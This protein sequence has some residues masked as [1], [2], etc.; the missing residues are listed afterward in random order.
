MNQTGNFE[1]LKFR[2]DENRQLL[3]HRGKATKIPPLPFEVLRYFVRNPNRVITKLE[4]NDRVWS[5]NDRGHGTIKTC[6]G[7]LRN[8][9]KD[10]SR[11][12][13]RNV[14][15]VGYEFTPKVH[16]LEQEVEVHINEGFL[17]SDSENSFNSNF[18]I[19]YESKYEKFVGREEELIKA[20]KLLNNSKPSIL[21][22][23]GIM[24]I[25]K[26]QFAI[27]FSHRFEKDYPGGCYW[28][29][30]EI[31]DNDF[32][33]FFG[34]LHELRGPLGLPGNS[35]REKKESI[36]EV[37]LQ[38]QKKKERALLIFDNAN[39]WE[40]L[41]GI[42]VALKNHH[43][44]LTTTNPRL[45]LDNASL[46]PLGNLD[47][48]SS[49]KLL[50]SSC[51]GKIK[52][53][54]KRGSREGRAAE[55]IV[56]L[57]GGHAFS[58]DKVASYFK[59]PLA[60]DSFLSYEKR[61]VEEGLTRT[62][63]ETDVQGLNTNHELRIVAAL[64]P[65]WERLNN[66]SDA[67]TLLCAAACFSPNPIR[68]DLLGKASGLIS[69][70][71]DDGTVPYIFQEL[72]KN[73]KLEEAG[74]NLEIPSKEGVFP[75]KYIVALKV[76]VAFGLLEVA[77]DK[78]ISCH[79]LIGDFVLNKLSEEEK[80]RCG[81][82]VG[83][84]LICLF[85][86]FKGSLEALFWEVIPEYENIR[87]NFDFWRDYFTDKSR[88]D[89]IHLTYI[90]QLSQLPLFYLYNG[91]I[92]K[93]A[94]SNFKIP[95]DL[96]RS[97]N[98]AI[99]D[100]LETRSENFEKQG[101]WEN[102]ITNLILAKKIKESR[103][104]SGS[105]WVYQL[106][107][108][109]G[110]NYGKCGRFVEAS[111]HYDKA[112]EFY[113]DHIENFNPDFSAFG[114][115]RFLDTLSDY[116]KLLCNMNDLY[117]KEDCLFKELEIARGLLGS[118]HHIVGQIL[119][120]I[121]YYYEETG[122]GKKFE[123]Y[124]KKAIRIRQRFTHR[125]YYRRDMLYDLH[126]YYFN[127]GNLVKSSI[128]YLKYKYSPVRGGNLKDYRQEIVQIKNLMETRKYTLPRV[129]ERKIFPQNANAIVS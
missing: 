2:F 35:D 66:Y 78:K 70:L 57:L 73:G 87:C 34:S 86:N 100:I 72:K 68:Q 85:E 109:L 114:S 17:D 77:S 47:E 96:L 94:H 9:L 44:L 13:I 126:E 24:G 4:L 52:P 76:C 7:V 127:Q 64:S 29:E 31:R 50:L 54:P 118:R 115:S 43:R 92:S 14:H 65:T 93:V 103:L 41:K 28:I 56:K 113:K 22:V 20:R 48:S 75:E 59:D 25:G 116:A 117:S 123:T 5:G 121:G 98:L 104:G 30:A 18:F 21:I 42:V 16:P 129:R 101:E 15:G 60:E 95:V 90:G 124:R 19:R 61:L 111:E 26:T 89:N 1:F 106:V 128:Y 122:E 74:I 102:A 119:R 46:L 6:I 71:N 108:K 11:S 97:N 53:I 88:F 82:R 80:H 125:E 3:W 8:F 49:L 105:K 58:L 79:R 91:F 112:L 62:L 38:L 107:R 99:S 10:K 120:M 110:E 69:I 27:E 36:K 39:N 45:N 63:D 67:K 81:V 55:S 33:S 32:S 84:S 51:D 40:A 37:I 23:Y 83:Y 12:I